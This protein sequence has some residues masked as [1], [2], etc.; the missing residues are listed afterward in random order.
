MSRV[1]LALTCMLALATAGAAA[2]NLPPQKKVLFF[3]KSSGYEHPVIKEKDGQH[4]FAAQVL[5]SQACQHRIEFTF[6][7]DGSKFTPAYLAQF[8]A[9][10]FYTS[11]DL[12]A[13]GRDGNAPMTAAGKADLLDAVRQGKGFVGV[14][15]AADTFHAGESAATNT[16]QPRHWRYRDLD[17]HTDPYTRMLGGELIIHGTQQ[18]A[19]MRVADP[20]FPGM[21][22]LAPSVQLMEEWY[23]IGSFARDMHVLLVHETGSMRD[24]NANGKDWPPPGANVP[25]QRPPYPSTWA[26]LHEQGRVFYTAMGHDETSWRNPLFQQLL[27]GGL[28]WATRQRDADV[29]PNLAQVTPQFAQLPPVSG[30]VPGLPKR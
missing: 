22:A 29:S 13:A 3:S 17:E 5:A 27:F 10:L 30:P 18:L 8:D 26:R 4:S 12:L 21:A 7:K 24:P 6:S 20:A 16:N 23:S 1:R 14:H 28:T 11:G 15:A 2:C 19:N 9:Y 25:Y